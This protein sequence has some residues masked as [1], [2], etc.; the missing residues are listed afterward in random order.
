LGLEV[1][2]HLPDIYFFVK[3]R[4]RRFVMC[5]EAFL[6]LMG[7]KR[8]SQLI[9]LR[10]QAFS[11]AHLCEK[12]YRDDSD[13]IVEGRTIVDEVEPVRNRDGSVDWF[14]TTKFPVRGRGDGAI[15][16]V[17]GIT[18]DLGK[19]RSRSERFLAMAP[20]IETILNDYGGPLPLS[21]LASRVS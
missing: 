20:V 21:M 9:G 12:Y 3:D 10:D 5:N 19:M 6:G 8:E 14:N 18:R 7:L 16:G 1:L 2:G 17:A 4:E 15:I 13:V 11:P